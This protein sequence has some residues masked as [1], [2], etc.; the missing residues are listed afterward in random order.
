MRVVVMWIND[1]PA[2]KQQATIHVVER[3]FAESIRNDNDD[4]DDD[5]NQRNET[6]ELFFAWANRISCKS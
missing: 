4:D 6:S 2:A 3:D 1:V 5:G